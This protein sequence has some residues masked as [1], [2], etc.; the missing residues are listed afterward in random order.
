SRRP[1]PGRR[2]QR[3]EAA[4]RL[5]DHEK[6]RIRIQSG[7]SRIHQR[8]RRT[9][10]QGVRNIV[11][12]VEARPSE[13]DEQVVLGHRATVD[14]DA[15]RLPRARTAATGGGSGVFGGPEHRHHA[16]PPCPPERSPRSATTLRATTASSNGSTRPPTICP[17]SWPFPAMSSTS[18]APSPA[19]AAAIASRRSP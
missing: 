10:A 14:R 16:P 2:R 18:S 5:V 8:R 12:P 6:R 17:C 4:L 3:F 13:R 7:R 1:V 9:P 15:A 19:T 11:V